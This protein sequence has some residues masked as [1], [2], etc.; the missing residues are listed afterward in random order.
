MTTE[1]IV[2][3]DKSELME[4]QRQV[5]EL[6]VHVDVARRERLVILLLAD[7]YTWTDIQIK[8]DCSIGF[9][10][11]WH[12]RLDAEH[13]VGLLSRHAGRERFKATDQIEVRV[14]AHTTKRKCP[15]ASRIGCRASS[16]SH[17]GS[18]FRI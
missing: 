4:L 1:Y 3:I 12:K 9:I 17:S 10:D 7:E 14:L 8:P 15:M 2:I 5:N 11:F 18:V 6:K 13:L 16:G